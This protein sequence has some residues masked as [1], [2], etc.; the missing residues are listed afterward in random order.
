MPTVLLN[1]FLIIYMI[2]GAGIA[3]QQVCEMPHETP[4]SMRLGSVIAG[5]NI[6]PLLLIAEYHN[7]LE[8]Q[9]PHEK[10]GAD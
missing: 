5:M 3:S 2:V 7:G 4:V 6:W 10:R 9:F 8:D 1:T